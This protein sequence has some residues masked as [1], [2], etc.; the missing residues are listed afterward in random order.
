[1]SAETWGTESSL[2]TVLELLAQD[3]PQHR[4]DELVQRARRAG[5]AADDVR[6]LERAVHLVEEVQ[7]ARDSRRR[8]ENGLA[9]LVET[10]RELTV[11][12]DLESLLRLVAQRVKRLL[13]LDM[14]C[15]ALQDAH[16]DLYIHTCEGSTTALV[17]GHPIRDS[18]GLGQ[19]A[20]MSGAPLWT[21]DY[22]GDDSIAHSLASDAVV[23]AEGV[24]ALLAVPLRNGGSSI[25]VL[26]AT[27]RTVRHFTP[28]EISLVDSFAALATV[29]IERADRLDRASNEVSELELDR[30]RTR[31]RL[32]RLQQLSEAHSST[33]DLLL[34]GADLDTVAKAM[35]DALDGA[36]QLRDT[37]GHFLAG[38]AE[39]PDLDEDALAAATLDAHTYRRPVAASGTTWVAPVT[40][41]AEE[42]GTLV[43]CP[44]T[45]LVGGDEWLLQLTAHAF[46]IQ[47]LLQRSAAVAEGSVR[48]DLFNELL[49]TGHSGQNELK[50]QGAGRLGVDLEVP[51]VLLVVRPEGGEPGRA[52]AWGSSY[53][54][55]VT[56]LK[57]VRDGC[58]VLLVPGR[59]TSA[60][61]RSVADEL[62]PLLGHPVSV[63]AAGPG[64]GADEVAR[65]Y[66]EAKRC[67]DALTALNRT[68]SVASMRDLG[69]LG[70][71]LSDDHDAGLFIETAIGPVLGYDSD[72]LTHLTGTLEAY[73]RSGASPTS[74]A[75]ALHVHPNTVSRRL[76]RITELLGARWQQPDRL[77]D[78]QLALRLHRIREVLIRQPGT[79]TGHADTGTTPRAMP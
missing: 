10:A 8:R 45:A 19:R 1:M 74:A 35:G 39:L 12:H 2:L 25:G 30:F 23:R 79:G 77:L 55:R 27:M 28:E 53:A 7:N 51:H 21:A 20:L 73:I 63:G 4:F 59:D 13:N 26:Y 14:T 71:L 50:V 31:T 44:A 57:T 22:L 40:A 64:R 24:R 72:R 46:A 17:I 15:V 34:S 29:A 69:F 6:R 67:L 76:E 60:I 9:E 5:A 3:A 68:G 75:E 49:T 47:L 58:V 43:L 32:V 52:V 41:G 62:S 65:M 16:Q 42:L 70:L 36:L 61:A 38:S 78:I 37:S 48:D 11:P 54:H 33:M 66:Q 56:G 18:R